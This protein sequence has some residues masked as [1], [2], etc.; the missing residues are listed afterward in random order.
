MMVG[1]IPEIRIFSEL[2]AFAVPVLAL[3]VHH[4]FRPVSDE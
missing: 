3:I 1:T 2:S 4:R